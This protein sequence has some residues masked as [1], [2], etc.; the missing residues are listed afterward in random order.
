MVYECIT[1]KQLTAIK[2]EIC[3]ILDSN[4]TCDR[5]K[6]TP[7]PPPPTSPPLLLA[8]T[9]RCI[10]GVNHLLAKNGYSTEQYQKA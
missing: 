10:L 2:D 7:F 3:F 8:W 5:K 6:L 4:C 1:L 9:F